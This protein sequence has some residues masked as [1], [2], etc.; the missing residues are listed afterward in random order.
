VLEVGSGSDCTCQD[1]VPFCVWIAAHH[2]HD[3]EAALWETV[4]GLGDIDTT[5]AIVGGIVA[6]SAPA[7]PEAWSAAR[8]PLPAAFR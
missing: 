1:T 5:C 7:I 4:L 2:L 8:E 6:L 3:Y